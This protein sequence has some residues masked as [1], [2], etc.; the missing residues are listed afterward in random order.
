MNDKPSDYKGSKWRSQ[1]RYND[2]MSSVFILSADIV[3]RTMGELVP[4]GG[5]SGK[6]ENSTGQCV[7]PSFRRRTSSDNEQENRET[8]YY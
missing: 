7:H 6:R 1:R 2:R 3:H 5:S 8:D 4:E